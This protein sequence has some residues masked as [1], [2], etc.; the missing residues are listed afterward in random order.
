MPAD[1]LLGFGEASLHDEVAVV[2]LPAPRGGRR[3]R[4]PRQHRA[5]RDAH[6]L[7]QHQGDGR[8]SDPVD[9]IDLRQCQLIVSSLGVA[10]TADWGGFFVA[11]VV[12]KYAMMM[13]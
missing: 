3:L 1:P 2:R 7:W 11:T 10:R 12:L 9:C 4:R 6:H 5:R 8:E 13:L